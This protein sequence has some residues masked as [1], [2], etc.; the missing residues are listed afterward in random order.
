MEIYHSRRKIW[1]VGKFVYACL[2][3]V[4]RGNETHSMCPFHGLRIH[5]LCI[6]ERRCITLISKLITLI[7]VC[8]APPGWHI[9]HIWPYI[10]MALL[11]EINYIW[12]RYNGEILWQSNRKICWWLF[13]TLESCVSCSICDDRMI[14]IFGKPDGDFKC[15]M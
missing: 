11:Y 7:C 14:I 8:M 5:A 1:L 10:Y 13:K 15:S 2:G 4:F 9:C 12:V 3:L 6:M